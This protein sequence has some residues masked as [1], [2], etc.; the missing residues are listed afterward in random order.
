MWLNIVTILKTLSPPC[1]TEIA[2][3]LT[4]YLQAGIVYATQVYYTWCVNVVC[5]TFVSSFLMFPK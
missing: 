1:H 2:V 3:F 5:T 4:F